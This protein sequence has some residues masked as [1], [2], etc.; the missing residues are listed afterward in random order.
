MFETLRRN[1][2]TLKKVFNK[3]DA[4]DTKSIKFEISRHFFF[5][6]FRHRSTGFFFKSRAAES[7]LLLHSVEKTRC[8]RG[9]RGLFSDI[10]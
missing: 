4:F 5:R 1:T 9:R 6:L 2:T 3:N 8:F 7:L 10:L